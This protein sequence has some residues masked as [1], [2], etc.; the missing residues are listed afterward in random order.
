[1]YHIGLL[2]QK[3]EEISNGIF[4]LKLEGDVTTFLRGI[5]ANWLIVFLSM[6][7]F[8]FMFVV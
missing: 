3:Y 8:H 7:S 6:I 1:M 5:V 2:A 4:Q